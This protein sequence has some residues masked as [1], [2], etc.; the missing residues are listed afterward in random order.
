MLTIESVTA[1][2]LSVVIGTTAD[3]TGTP[4]QFAVSQGTD[5]GTFVAGTWAGS[6]NS[7]TGEAEALTPVLGAGQALAVTQGDWR[8]YA[9][10]T[11]AGESPVR[12][13][14]ILRIT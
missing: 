12:V 8:L 1:E 13:A 9:K 2:R 10:W 6:W 14:A 11:V 5:P 4:P 3:P 7:T